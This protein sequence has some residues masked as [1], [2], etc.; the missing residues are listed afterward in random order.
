MWPF[1]I[2]AKAEFALGRIASVIRDIARAHELQ[3]RTEIRIRE[4]D[5]CIRGGSGTTVVRAGACGTEEK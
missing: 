2:K 5:I 4:S 3:N 1:V